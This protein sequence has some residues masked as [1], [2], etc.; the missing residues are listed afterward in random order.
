MPLDRIC[1]NLSLRESLPS[2]A[3]FCILFSLHHSRDEAVLWL[4]SFLTTPPLIPLLNVT[5]NDLNTNGLNLA[6]SQDIEGALVPARRAAGRRQQLGG[7]SLQKLCACFYLDGGYIV[8]LSFSPHPLPIRALPVSI[9]LSL[10]RVQAIDWLEL[11]LKSEKGSQSEQALALSP[12]G[13][14]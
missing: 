3:S 4:R 7:G 2:A 12:R 1:Y 14:L 8:F 6:R 5:S 11:A 9:H 10:L 13:N